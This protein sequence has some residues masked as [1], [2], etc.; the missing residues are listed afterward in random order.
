[1]CGHHS[2]ARALAACKNFR[3]DDPG[4]LRLLSHAELVQ[5][6]PEHVVN[7]NDTVLLNAKQLFV[8]SPSHCQEGSGV[9]L[10]LECA[11]LRLELFTK[12]YIDC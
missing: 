5:I 12:T 6:L 8:V 1:M 7:Q 3:S 2:N 10:E 9:P 11:E 4:V